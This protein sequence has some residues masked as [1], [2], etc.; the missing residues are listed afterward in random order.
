MKLRQRVPGDVRALELRA[1]ELLF[2]FV[3]LLGLFLPGAVFGAPSDQG[4]ATP[5]VEMIDVLYFRDGGTTGFA[6]KVNGRL[7]HFCLDGRMST[8]PKT[9][10]IFLGATH[11]TAPEATRT[12]IA[13]EEESRVLGI[14]DAWLNSELSTAEQSALLAGDAPRDSIEK[15]KMWWTLRVREQLKNR[16][17]KTSKRAAGGGSSTS[18]KASLS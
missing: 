12:A 6:M 8:T 5:K 13:G 2:A 1:K 14:L 3:F 16:R 9:R 4:S 11:P 15:T 18:C 10:H 17:G 7:E